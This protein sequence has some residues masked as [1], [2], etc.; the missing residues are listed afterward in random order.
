M[1]IPTGKLN[2]KPVSVEKYS[3][4]RHHLYSEPQASYTSLVWGCFYYLQIA[5]RLRKS[6]SRTYGFWL[7]TFYIC[8]V[9]LFYVQIILHLQQTSL[10]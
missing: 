2:M 3:V 8:F 9:D 7:I 10:G 1:H 6:M 4:T 5:S